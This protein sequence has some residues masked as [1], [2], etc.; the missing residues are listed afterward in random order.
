LVPAMSGEPACLRN[1]VPVLWKLVPVSVKVTGALFVAADGDAPVRLGAGFTVK[2]P[3]QGP[4]WLS[5]F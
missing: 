5:V 1:T 4:D 2:H 3:A